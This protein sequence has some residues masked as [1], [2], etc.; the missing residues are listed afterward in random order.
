MAEA[1]ATTQTYQPVGIIDWRTVGVR[2]KISTE[3]WTVG[4]GAHASV[5]PSRAARVVIQGPPRGSTM[6]TL[7]KR[8]SVATALALMLT[9][10]VGLTQAGGAKS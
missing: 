3:K 5:G 8:A 6:K 2:T 4:E 7:V 9:L 1:P 10:L